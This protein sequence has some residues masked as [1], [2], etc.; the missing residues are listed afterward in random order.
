MKQMSAVDIKAIISELKVIEDGRIDKIY[1]NPPDEIRIRIRKPGS[2]FELIIEAGK[3]IHL[4]KFPRQA[5]RIPSSFA[6][7]LRKHLEGGR[8]RRIYQHDFDRIVFVEVERE[9]KKVLIAEIFKKGNVILADE[10]WKI[11]MPLK[12]FF[13]SG[14]TYRLPKPQKSPFELKKE[15][16]DVLGDKEIVK[17]LATSLSVGGIYAEEICLR[18]GINKKKLASELNDEEKDRI[19]RAVEEIFLPIANESFKPHILIK[20]GEYADF[21]P[22][23]LRIFDDYEKKYFD[24]FNDAVD[25]FYSRKIVEEAEKREEE[26]KE[27]QRLRKRLEDQLSA[28]E[29]FEREMDEL[30][31]KG[32]FIYEQYTKIEKIL[33]VF[34]KAREK[35]SWDEIKEIVKKDKK[36]R[37]LVKDINSAENRVSVRLDGYTIDLYLDKTLP[38]IADIYYSK[39]KKIR[40]K[41][42]GVL[43]AIDNTKAAMEKI[44]NEKRFVTSIRVSRKR[45]WYERFRW[46]ITSEGFLVIGGRNAKMNEEIVSRY[47]EKNDLFFHTQVPGAPAT[48]LKNGQSAGEKSLEEAAIFSATYSSLWR[49]GKYSGEVYYVRPEQVKRSAK[50]GEYLARG[51]FYIEGKRNYISAEVS[52]AIGVDLKNLRV[53]GGPKSAVE[54][55]ADYFVE[56]DIGDKTPNEISIEIASKLVEMAKEDEKY[57]VRSIS[58]PDEIMKF[59]PPGKSRIK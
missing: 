44:K 57:I 45:E 25:E 9:E 20:E 40:Q 14:E 43:K 56:I 29:R 4:T 24:S 18:A 16:L 58:T 28:K 6:M 31:K 51:S 59:L 33:D 19:V 35:K 15:D 39:A 2:K 10:N 7:L 49:E 22:I 48:I 17:A 36:L 13:K 46:F 30:R 21:L 12:P 53:I 1:H 11:I 8:I 52:C 50:A 41:Y 55:Y 3:R 27:L 47:M 5:P 26:N 32:D 54:K 23:E 37:E 34:R 38:Q 42:E